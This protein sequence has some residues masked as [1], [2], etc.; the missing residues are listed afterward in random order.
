VYYI[1]KYKE[2]YDYKDISQEEDVFKK[3][4]NEINDEEK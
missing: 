1:K 2:M 3:L 4:V